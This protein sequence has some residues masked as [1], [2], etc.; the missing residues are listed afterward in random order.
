MDKKSYYQGTKNP[1]D[2][3]K[4]DKA[5]VIYPGRFEEPFYQNYDLYDTPEG[6]R[7]VGPGT[8]HMSGRKKFKSVK[9]FIEDKRKRMKNRYVAKD[10]YRADDKVQKAADLISNKLIKEAQYLGKDYSVD[11]SGRFIPGQ[12]FS[13]SLDKAGPAYALIGGSPL[14][15]GYTQE[16]FSKENNNPKPYSILDENFA[17]ARKAK[18]K[19]KRIKKIYDLLGRM[20]NRGFYGYPYGYGYGYNN[21]YDNRSYTNNN[22]SPEPSD[23]GGD[24]GDGGDA[25]GDGGGE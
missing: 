22:S 24:V 13:Q 11:E 14:E 17:K 3:P 12:G 10:V 9:E 8:G 15:F 1:K 6:D 4:A 16:Y 2:K 20:N 25:G 18:K 7:G 19:K 23:P 21:Y 5:L